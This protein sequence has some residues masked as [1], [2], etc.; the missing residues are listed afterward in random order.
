MVDTE[1]ENRVLRCIADFA[2]RLDTPEEVDACDALDA[3][4]KRYGEAVLREVSSLAR[5]VAH[6]ALILGLVAH[7]RGQG[8]EDDTAL[9]KAISGANLVDRRI[10]A[11]IEAL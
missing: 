6:A 2:A 10:S 3:M 1:T 4:A 11:L 7:F 5:D 9:D 8:D